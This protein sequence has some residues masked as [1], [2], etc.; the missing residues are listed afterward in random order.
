MFNTIAM[1]FFPLFMALAAWS[2]LFTMRISNRLV[3]LLVAGFCIVGL[4][5]GLSLEQ[6]LWHLAAGG[7]VLVVAFSF[8]AMGWIGGGDAKLAAATALWL[9]FAVTLPYVIYAALFGGALTLTILA[10]RRWPLPANLQQVEWIDRLHDRK[11]GV[12]YGIALAIAGILVYSNSPIF[13]QL[14]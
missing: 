13:M 7:L 12:P 10:V 2:D 14:V 8:F 1:M 4:V 6:F 11:N 9:G 3:L 5:A